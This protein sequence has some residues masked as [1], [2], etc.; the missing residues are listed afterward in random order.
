MDFFK[1]LHI[2]SPPHMHSVHLHPIALTLYRSP[3]YAVYS[4]QCSYYT[5]IHMYI[6]CKGRVQRFNEKCLLYYLFTRF[7]LGPNSNS[8]REDRQGKNRQKMSCTKI[9]IRFSPL[10]F[11]FTLVAS[12]DFF[13]HINATSICSH[14]TL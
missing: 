9:S 1:S 13:L 8:E 10:R 7:S 5:H 2:P 12:L 6:I 11:G 4:V 14:V 3:Y